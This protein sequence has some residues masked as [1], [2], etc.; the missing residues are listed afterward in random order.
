MDKILKIIFIILVFTV[1]NVNA[2]Q[3]SAAREKCIAFGY[4]P[5][6]D[7]F[8]ACVQME[9]YRNQDSGNC[10]NLKQ[11]INQRVNSCRSTCMMN[12][13]PQMRNLDGCIARCEQ[14]LNL[15]PSNC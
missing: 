7:N 2:Q 8:A 9:T 14:Q 5:G 12:V 4:T 1:A 3:M 10:Q 15:L 13:D 6:N 11:Q